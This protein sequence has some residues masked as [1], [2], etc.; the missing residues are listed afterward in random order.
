MTDP[1]IAPDG[2]TYDREP[3]FRWLQ[4]HDTSPK[5]GERLTG[6]KD[7]LP[8]HNLLRLIRDL[9]EAK[10]PAM[11]CPDPVPNPVAARETRRTALVTEKTLVLKCLGPPESQWAGRAFRVCNR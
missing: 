2:H 4:S 9:I 11:F 5:T 6:K 8:N 10:S 3:I 7:L 1:V